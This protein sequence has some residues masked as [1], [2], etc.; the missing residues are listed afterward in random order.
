MKK[1]K[2]KCPRDSTLQPCGTTSVKLKKQTPSILDMLE[3]SYHA[4]KLVYEQG[5]LKLYSTN[6]I[7]RNALRVQFRDESDFLT[8]DLFEVEY[9]DKPLLEYKLS[10]NELIKINHVEFATKDAIG[11]WNLLIRN[12]QIKCQTRNQTNFKKT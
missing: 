4:F 9:N 3:R 6:D 2:K 1:V 5:Y 8:D 7:I 10:W 12:K 11:Y